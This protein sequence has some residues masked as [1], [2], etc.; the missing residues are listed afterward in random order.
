MTLPN[1]PAPSGQEPSFTWASRWAEGNFPFPPGR[2]G[3]G[4][5]GVVVVSSMIRYSRGRGRAIL[6]ISPYSSLVWRHH[7]THTHTHS[8]TN[9]GKGKSKRS[10]YSW[11]GLEIGDVNIANH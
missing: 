2:S 8:E 5:M 6:V 4:W 11:C 3:L 9:N 10:R 1:H 7:N